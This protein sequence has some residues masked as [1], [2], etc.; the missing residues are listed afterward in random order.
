MKLS[1]IKPLKPV[2][3][4]FV[5]INHLMIID[6]LKD[7]RNTDDMAHRFTLAQIVAYVKDHPVTQERYR[8]IFE[9]PPSTELLNAVRDM[10]VDQI[11]NLASWAASILKNAMEGTKIKGYFR[12]EDDI[13]TYL[14]WI[15]QHQE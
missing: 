12:P 14:R 15:N 8:E 11:R 10:D 13:L 5:P 4:D 9:F 7:G 6:N 3:E 1:E 2:N